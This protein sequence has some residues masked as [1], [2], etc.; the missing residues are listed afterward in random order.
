MGLGFA[1]MKWVVREAAAVARGADLQGCLGEE[2]SLR[3]D[4]NICCSVVVMLKKKLGMSKTRGLFADSG[5]G[6]S[7]EIGLSDVCSFL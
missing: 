6:C 3:D 1:V 5:S 2:L 7:E 4:W